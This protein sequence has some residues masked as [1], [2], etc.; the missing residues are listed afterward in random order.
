[1]TRINADLEPKRLAD[2]HLMAEYQELA[3]VHASLRRSLRARPATKVLAG[4]PPHYV[5]GKGHVSFF[6]DKLLFL[7]RRYAALVAELKARNYNLNPD[8]KFTH[9]GEFPPEFYN[10]W[11]PTAQDRKIIAERLVSRIQQKPEWYRYY[12]VRID[13]EFVPRHYGDLL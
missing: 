2:Q 10:D 7:E 8:R 12:G 1:M 3:M 5:L 13:E 9:E 6:Y 11:T 4:L